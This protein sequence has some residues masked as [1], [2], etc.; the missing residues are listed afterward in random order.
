[1]RRRRFLTVTAAATLAWPARSATPA[2]WS[3][4]AMGAAA[5][6]VLHG[7]EP[8]RAR[9]VFARIEAELSRVEAHF[10]L[11]RDSAL[12]RLNRN[13]RLSHPAPEVVALFA[14][15]ARVHRATGGAFDPSIQPLWLATATEGD[16]AAARRLVGWHRVRFDAEEIALAPG[17]ALTFNGIAQGAAADRVA[18][19]LRT[20]GFRDVLIDMGEV[21]ALGLNDGHNWQAA[22]AAPDGRELARV[23]LADRAL[24]TSSPTG[25]RIGRDAAHILHPD[26]RAAIWNTVS[27]SAPEAA[28]ADALSTAFCLMTKAEITRALE[29]FEDTKIEA[30]A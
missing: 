15:A 14:L 7:A 6:V 18:D 4:R 21:M 5:R 17:Q 10:S 2:I 13:G 1:M 29:H 25:T 8:Y 24:A 12:T 11:H 19:L 3:G 23:A 20:E 9:R 30:I 28:T 26:G 27:V 16:V 22:V